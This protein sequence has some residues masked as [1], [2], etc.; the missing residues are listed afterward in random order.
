MLVQAQVMEEEKK[1]SVS[2]KGE[3]ANG[4]KSTPKFD[5]YIYIL[6]G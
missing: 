1:T 6:L 5:D 2:E 3:A 4:N